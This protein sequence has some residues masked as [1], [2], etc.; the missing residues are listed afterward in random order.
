MAEKD[1]RGEGG[2][3]LG[4]SRKKATKGEKHLVRA[5]AKVHAHNA[6]ARLHQLKQLL[7]RL[8]NRAFLLNVMMLVRMMTI[9]FVLRRGKGGAFPSFFLFYPP[10]PSSSS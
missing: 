10:P 6:H 4:P 9:I 8:R 5:V 2:V 1:E 7:D 3:K